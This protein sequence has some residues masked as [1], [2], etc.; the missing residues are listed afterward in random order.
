MKRRP[1]VTM[2]GNVS[3]RTWIPE[4]WEVLTGEEY[5]EIKRKTLLQEQVAE[6]VCVTLINSASKSFQPDQIFD[7]RR[8]RPFPSFVFILFPP[9]SSS[10]FILSPPSSSPYTPN[11]PTFLRQ[12]LLEAYKTLINHNNASN[13]ST[14]VALASTS[15]STT[16]TDVLLTVLRCHLGQRGRQR[17]PPRALHI[18]T[19]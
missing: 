13:N 18:A 8:L 3:C 15:K 17:K 2:G 4:I 6:E 11:N 5:I 7:F 10:I 12:I 9:S 14:V 1:W 19:E 16:T